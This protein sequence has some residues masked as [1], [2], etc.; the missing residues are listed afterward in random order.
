M[1]DSELVDVEFCLLSLLVSATVVAD[2][3][4]IGLS[5]LIGVVVGLDSATEVF[6]ATI[7]D[8]VSFVAKVVVVGFDSVTEVLGA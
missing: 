8:L 2:C 4:V 3:S 6:G 5:D 1:S 7:S